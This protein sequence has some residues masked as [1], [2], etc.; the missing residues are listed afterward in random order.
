MTRGTTRRA[1][2]AIAAQEHCIFFSNL[3]NDRLDLYWAGYRDGGWEL[4]YQRHHLDFAAVW[5][6]S[7][8]SDPPGIQ[9]EVD[10]LVTVPMR[11]GKRE[12]TIFLLLL[13]TRAL[14]AHLSF[15]PQEKAPLTL[16]L[17]GLMLHMQRRW[18][19]RGRSRFDNSAPV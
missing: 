14:V 12:F 3:E 8:R 9:D 5:E 1:A 19:A 10:L 13:Y 16:S 4:K 11:L 18:L 15:W 2:L 17:L 6:K 7:V